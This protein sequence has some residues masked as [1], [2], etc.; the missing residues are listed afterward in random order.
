MASP[1]YGG[2]R[3]QLKLA[4]DGRKVGG[5]SR[6]ASLGYQFPGSLRA[7]VRARIRARARAR[8]RKLLSLSASHSC[9]CVGR[10]DSPTL[11]IPA[12]GEKRNQRG[13]LRGL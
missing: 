3:N 5:L 6:D 7:R 13:G 11:Q 1:C 9:G 8:A 12:R 4:T 10:Y 2:I